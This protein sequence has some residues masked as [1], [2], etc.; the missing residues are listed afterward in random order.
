MKPSKTV[1]ALFALVALVQ[2]AVVGWILYAHHR[3]MSQGE[4]IRLDLGNM[5]IYD[6]SDDTEIF[7]GPIITPI[8]KDAVFEYS[9]PFPPAEIYESL[10][11][12]IVFE[13]NEE[14]FS[15]PERWTL[16]RPRDRTDYLEVRL[17]NMGRAD[18]DKLGINY[19]FGNYRLDNFT[20]SEELTR[21]KELGLYD[22]SL[23]RGVQ[24]QA[25]AYIRIYK[26]RYA[27]ERIHFDVSREEEGEQNPLQ[28]KQENESQ[29]ESATSTGAA[30]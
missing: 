11:A 3:V 8:S 18:P 12:W 20:F 26:G 14:G 6:L 5:W 21:L 29:S 28:L 2:L 19:L 4:L 16:N 13:T 10:P 17:Q 30:E 27:V 24:Y 22:G 15:E 1:V 9:D 23:S 25:S 7:I